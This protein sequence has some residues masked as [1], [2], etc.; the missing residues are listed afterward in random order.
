MTPPPLPLV[1]AG[2]LDGQGRGQGGGLAFEAFRE[3][4]EICR[5]HREEDVAGA[6]V[7]LLRYHP[8]ASVPRHEHGGV[9]TIVVLEGSQSDEHGRYAKGAV[10]VNAAG[11]RHTVRSEEGCLVLIVWARPVRLLDEAPEAPPTAA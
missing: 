4:V 1:L 6:E 9:E 7:A 8:G 3:G 5:L 2:L 10:V 11:S